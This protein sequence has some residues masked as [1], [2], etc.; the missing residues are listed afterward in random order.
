[1]L[2]ADIKVNKR[3]SRFVKHAPSVFAINPTRVVRDMA[4]KGSSGKSRKAKPRSKFAASDEVIRFS[5]YRGKAGEHFVLA[6]L[7]MQSFNAAL[8]AVDAGI[9]IL[10]EKKDKLFRIQVKSRKV[11]TDL[12][13]SFVLSEKSLKRKLKPNFYVIV[14]MHSNGHIDYLILPSMVVDSMIRRSNIIYQIRYKRFSAKLINRGQQW[15]IR[16]REND[17]TKYINAWHL[18]R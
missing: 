14:L 11:G 15:F 17:I 7:L 9:D 5:S 1:M 4:T 16:N 10:A 18:I 8:V 6:H 12:R 13:S 2:N 3:H